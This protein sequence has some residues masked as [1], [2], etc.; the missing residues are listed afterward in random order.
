VLA[1]PFLAM[2]AMRDRWVLLPLLVLG[3]TGTANILGTLSGFAPSL[4]AA[5]RASP[6]PRILPVVNLLMLAL[7]AVSLLRAT[8]GR[9]SN[10]F[11][12]PGR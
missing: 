6:L 7:L 10:V 12:A 5:I 2:L 9:T 1:L 4:Y 8:K 3:F 11:H